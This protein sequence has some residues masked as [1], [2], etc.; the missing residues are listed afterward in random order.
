LRFHCDSQAAI[1]LRH[2]CHFESRGI[3]RI[4]MSLPL[5]QI[6]VAIIAGGGFALAD[7]SGGCNLPA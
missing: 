4:S 6:P 1:F 7:G 2:V 3:F 5:S